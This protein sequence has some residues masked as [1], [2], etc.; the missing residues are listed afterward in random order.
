MSDI[1][2]AHNI[3]EA[4]YF[5]TQSYLRSSDLA[6]ALYFRYGMSTDD[7]P[8]AD[9]HLSHVAIRLPPFWPTDPAI[10][11]AQAEA[12]FATRNITNETTMFR[13]IVASLSPETAV[14]VRDLLLN[15]PTDQ[16]YTVLKETL[17]RRTAE[18]AQLR[19]QRL[20][21]GEELGDRK[22][23][24][25]LRRMQQLVGDASISD[26]FMR[27]LFLQRLPPNIQL[28]LSGISEDLTLDK[29]AQLAD[30][31][32]ET[33]VPA[34][35]AATESAPSMADTINALHNAVDKLQR[36]MSQLQR[37]QRSHTFRQR[38]RSASR[39]RYPD[40]PDLCFYHWRYGDKA[41]KC[42]KSTC[43]M[44]LNDHAGQ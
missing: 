12:Q 16:P 25:L 36:Q 28:V 20:I 17:T 24:Q 43:K 5:E 8:A 33:Q 30:R 11:F 6:F 31:M 14:E 3:G 34:V 10:W 38:S 4:D 35:S 23:S 37:P 40:R 9:T 39:T 42:N 19:V 26:T 13:H 41:R 29:Q 15:P 21:S 22:P 32:T 27:Q 18:S 7:H 44:S 2:P 1:N